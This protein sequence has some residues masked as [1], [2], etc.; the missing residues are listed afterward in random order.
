M[1]LISH[2]SNAT[3]KTPKYHPAVSTK[4][5]TVIFL[6]PPNSLNKGKHCNISVYYKS[7]NI[8]CKPSSHS[9]KS[10]VFFTQIYHFCDNH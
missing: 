6:L 4:E 3:P 10:V 1:S 7:S 8:D 2:I 5:N 9:L